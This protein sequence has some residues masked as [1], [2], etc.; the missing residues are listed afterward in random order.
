MLKKLSEEKIT[1]LLETGIAE[2][3]KYGPDKANI[4]VIAKKSGVS[5]GVLYKYYKNKDDFFQA[6][7]RRSLEALNSVLEEV[8]NCEG[9][10]LER[11]EKLIRA[12]QNSAKTQTIYNV[13]YHKITAESCK[14]YTL[15]YAREIESLSSNVYSSFIKNAQER[16]DVRTDMDA[17]M[18]AF[19]F[20]NLLTMLQFSYC[21]DYYKERFEIYCGK[22]ILL[23]DEKVAAQ[24]LKFLE[25]AFT[26][27]RASISHRKTSKA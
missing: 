9:K 3:S 17:K 15:A 19:F 24:L 10:I 20:D 1:E 27:E 21:C 2:F 25:S 6:C 18:L 26:T 7:F 13:L 5:V 23:D 16:G 22:G 8:V 11:A 12:V 4:N 14:Q